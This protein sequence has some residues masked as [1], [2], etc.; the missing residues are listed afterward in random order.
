VLLRL[1]ADLERNG[2]HL[3]VDAETLAI[4]V[5]AAIHGLGLEFL[6]RGATPELRRAVE[7]AQH[8]LSLVFA[9]APSPVAQ[10]V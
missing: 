7:L 8:V 3:L 2:H 10:E 4:L 1:V 6:E 5:A 9:Q